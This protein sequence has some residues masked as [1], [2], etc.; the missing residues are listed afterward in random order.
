[1]S[2][3]SIPTNILTDRLRRLEATGLVKRVRGQNTRR[4]QYLPTKMGRDLRPVILALA[5][6]G[7]TY[8]E[9]TWVPP[10]DYLAAT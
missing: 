5:N 1:R 2:A 3:E 7:N 4:Y 9:D 6:W 8:I 10:D